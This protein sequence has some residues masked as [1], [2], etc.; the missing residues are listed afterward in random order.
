MATT[1]DSVPKIGAGWDY[2]E[3]TYTYDED[4]DPSTGAIITYN[5][6]GT[7]TVWTAINKP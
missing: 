3:A 2:D 1:W 4:L 7:A 5:S 6:A